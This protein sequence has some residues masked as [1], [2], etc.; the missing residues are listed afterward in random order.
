MEGKCVNI[1]RMR[2]S[3]CENK[4]ILGTDKYNVSIRERIEINIKIKIDYYVL[5]T[6]IFITFFKY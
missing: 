6:H 4:K 3:E 2:K 1:K 5:S